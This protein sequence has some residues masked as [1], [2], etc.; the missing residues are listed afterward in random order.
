LIGDA[1]ELRDVYNNTQLF[2]VL[3]TGNGHT[4]KDQP[5]NVVLVHALKLFDRAVGVPKLLEALLLHRARPGKQTVTKPVPEFTDLVNFTGTYRVLVIDDKPENLEIAKVVLKGH[6]VVTVGSLQEAVGELRQ[7]TFH[8]VL[9]DMEMPPDKTY[10]AL[11]LDSFGVTETVSYG[12]A[13]MLEATS[14][15]LP[16]AIV[17]DGNHHQSWVSAM[18]DK[19]EGATVNGQKVLFFNHLGKRWDKALKALME[20]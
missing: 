1:K 10:Q 20:A 5:E 15:G 2:C 13:V 18:F 12:F 14:C 17:T 8:A 16:V 9:T 4:A 3:F 7:G 11:N 19:I 6:E